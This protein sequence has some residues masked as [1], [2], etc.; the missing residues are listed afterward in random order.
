MQQFKWKYAGDYQEYIDGGGRQ[1]GEEEAVDGGVTGNELRGVE[2]PAFVKT[3]TE[4]V[5]VVVV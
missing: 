2:V 1:G 4:G 5:E 3:L